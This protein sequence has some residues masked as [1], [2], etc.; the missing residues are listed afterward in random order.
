MSASVICIRGE[1]ISLTNWMLKR[2]SDGNDTAGDASGIL[3]E[4]AGEPERQENKV[5]F[6]FKDGNARHIELI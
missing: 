2:N 4:D 5:P 6:L 1:N 3:K